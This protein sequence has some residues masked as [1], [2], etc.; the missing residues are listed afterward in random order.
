MPYST[1]HPIILPRGSQLARLIISNLHLVHLHAGPTH[2][3]GLLSGQ[4]YVLGARN[5]VRDIS[6]SC[7]PCQRVYAKT[8]TQQMEDLPGC[9]VMPSPPFYKIGVDYAGPVTLK[10][11]ATRKPTYLKA[12]IALFV[13]LAT[14]AVHLELVSDLSSNDFLA[15]LRRFV[16]RRGCLAEIIS[17]NGTNF[18]EANHALQRV[19]WLTTSST[20]N[21]DI[22]P[23]L[24]QHCINCLAEPHILEACGKP[25]SSLQSYHYVSFSKTMP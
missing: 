15:A 19:Y 12:Y 13:C 9:R 21:K 24:T 8:S 11:G 18:V 10:R 2:L 17:D 4:F 14:K 16:S 23:F 5:L 6:R 7:V 3:M 22:Q 20:F 1:E 25:E